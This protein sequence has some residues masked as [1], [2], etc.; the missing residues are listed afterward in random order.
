MKEVAKT[1]FKNIFDQSVEE[2]LL[3]QL[4]SLEHMP[5][6]FS[7]DDNAEVWR[8]VT[9][10]E[11]EHILQHMPKDKSPGPDGWIQEFV[12]AFSDLVGDDL[13]RVVEESII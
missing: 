5:R 13:L 11:L 1:Y 8:H 7:L 6:M 3:A 9:K 4:H 10:A 2:D 12:S